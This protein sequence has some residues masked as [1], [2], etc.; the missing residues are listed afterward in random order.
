MKVA[1]SKGCSNYKGSEKQ[2]NVDPN[3]RCTIPLL[4]VIV[5]SNVYY[6]KGAMN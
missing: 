2:K 3:I 1:M 6:Q 4:T 5:G